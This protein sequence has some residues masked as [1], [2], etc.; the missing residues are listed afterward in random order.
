MKNKLILLFIILLGLT[1]VVFASL[2]LNSRTK[3]QSQ[4]QEKSDRTV[5]YGTQTN[6][7]GSV[8][9][10]AIPISL[11][12]GKNASFTLTFTTHTGDLSYDIGT[13][14][15]L[16]DNKGNIYNPVSWTGG[17]GGHH[18]E[19][20]LTFPAIAES[21]QKLTLTVPGIDNQDRVFEWK[22]N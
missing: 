5:L 17:K 18:I 2:Q 20:I 9:V 15:K 7:K 3:T 1:V 12:R 4:T 13:I 22:L 19:G 10:E 8:I 16:T 6:E 21:T 11:T 14:A